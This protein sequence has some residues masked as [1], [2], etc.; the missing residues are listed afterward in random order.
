M[1]LKTYIKDSTVF[2]GR[3]NK[4]TAISTN[5]EQSIHVYTWE[6]FV[7]YINKQ[8]LAGSGFMWQYFRNEI[9]ASFIV[10]NLSE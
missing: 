4:R 10:S 7:S 1:E 5:F 8:T 9:T 2:R 3:I 6:L